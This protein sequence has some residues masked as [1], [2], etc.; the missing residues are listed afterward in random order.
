MPESEQK[1]PAGTM[2]QLSEDFEMGVTRSTGDFPGVINKLEGLVTQ[3]ARKLKAGSLF[4]FVKVMTKLL[5]GLKSA[6]A[7]DSQKDLKDRG[8]GLCAATDKPADNR[9]VFLSNSR[10]WKPG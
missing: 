4:N 9:N 2:S 3:S 10:M 8:I 7:R 5:E 6:A 1:L